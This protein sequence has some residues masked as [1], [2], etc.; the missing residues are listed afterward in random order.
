MV[1]RSASFAVRGNRNTF[2]ERRVACNVEHA[3]SSEN[4]TGSGLLYVVEGKAN[5]PGVMLVVHVVLTINRKSDTTFVGFHVSI[6][7]LRTTSR[8]GLFSLSISPSI[9]FE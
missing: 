4:V 9:F 3:C 7:I 1:R 6:H 5:M 2:S 8:R